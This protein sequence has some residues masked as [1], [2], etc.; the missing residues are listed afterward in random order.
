[1]GEVY[2]GGLTG[3][4]VKQGK[5]L[6]NKRPVVT[7]YTCE[8]CHDTAFLVWTPCDHAGCPYI[9]KVNGHP[10]EPCDCARGQAAKALMERASRALRRE[11]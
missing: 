11:A 9:W 5:M 1:M 6:W 4:E 8:K 10:S 7:T 3:A 2:K